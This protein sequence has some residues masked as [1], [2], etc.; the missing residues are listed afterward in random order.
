MT[1]ELFRFWVEMVR[2]RPCDCHLWASPVFVVVAD[3]S[4]KVSLCL[5]ARVISP[6]L[7]KFAVTQYQ[8]LLW[9][10]R[11]DG[12][13]C[14]RVVYAPRLSRLRVGPVCLVSILSHPPVSP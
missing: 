13:C 5:H 1:P 4:C 7:D 2:V 12:P 6:N 3:V 8:R 10:G 14:L 9:E 11:L